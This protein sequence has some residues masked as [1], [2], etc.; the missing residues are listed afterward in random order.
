[1]AGRRSVTPLKYGPIYSWHRVKRHFL[2]S[3]YSLCSV[4]RHNVRF[5]STVIGWFKKFRC[6]LVSIEDALHGRWP[7]TVSAKIG[8]RVK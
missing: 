6:G 4:Y 5:F 3:V 8:A 7:K 1:M 2:C